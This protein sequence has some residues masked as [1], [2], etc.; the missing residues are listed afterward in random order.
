MQLRGLMNAYLEGLQWVCYYY[1]RGPD[2]CSWSWYYPYFYAPM[3][4]DLVRYDQLSRGPE[5][6]LDVGRPF[7]PFQQLMGVLPSYSKS[8]LPKVYQDL[9]DDPRSPILDFYPKVFKI[10]IDGVRV[11]WGGVTMIPFIDPP[12]L[13]ATMEDVVQRHG[14][15]E[16]ALTEAERKR[17][18]IGTAHIF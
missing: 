14:G 8:L 12:K 11:P 9:F 13:V 6:R 7:A 3:I 15:S 5:M 1:Y 16:V 4:W 18:S 10:D 17:N 2:R